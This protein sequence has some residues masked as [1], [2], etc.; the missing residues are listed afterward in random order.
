MKYALLAAAFMLVPRSE[1][2][3]QAVMLNP[4]LLCP[5]LIFPLLL[6]YRYSGRSGGGRTGSS[7]GGRGRGRGGCAAAGLRASRPGRR[8]GGGVVGPGL[9]NRGAE[10]DA[11]PLCSW[12]GPGGSV[13]RR[14][15]HPGL[16]VGRVFVRAGM[17]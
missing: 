17:A 13:E 10:G 11:A 15:A 8:V 6:S 16:V 5:V 14:C 4:H 3:L 2:P 9:L 1:E 7:G 12:E